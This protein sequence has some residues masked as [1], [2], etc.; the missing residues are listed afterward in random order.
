[1]PTHPFRFGIIAT[2]RGT[3]EQWLATARRIA[4]LGYGSLLV[5]DGLGLHAPFP[6]LA[7]AAAAVPDLRV[8]TFVLAAP[9]RP[10]RSAAWEAHSMTALTGGRFDFG[11]GTGRPDARAEAEQLGMPWA[12]GAQRL[13]LVRETIAH[14]RS[15]DGGDLDAPRTPVLLAAA[16]PRAMALAATEADIVTLAAPPLAERGDV[17]RMADELRALAGDRAPQLELAMNVFIV[18]DDI[19]PWAAHVIDGDPALLRQRD[20]LAVLRGSVSEM[21]D[22]LRR[23][24]DTLG[25]SYLAVSE[26]FAD[27]LAPVAE[28]IT[29]T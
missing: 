24:R 7:T 9:L 21:A 14:L 13:E 10:P 4:D 3:G 1:M 11:I 23:R 16:G 18:G 2:P 20:T 29:G 25:V 12:S 8:G 6:A 5:P 27:D 22:E 28:L 26:A 17:Q 19:P 15:L